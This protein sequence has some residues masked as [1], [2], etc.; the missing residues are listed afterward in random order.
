[1]KR[2]KTW[3]EKLADSKDLPR[4]E[5][6]PPG[7]SKMWGTGTIVI[8]A[9]KE[10]EEM[11][12]KVPKGKLATINSIREA[13]ALKHKATIGCPI[14]I[15]IFARI[16]AEVAKEDENE[17]KMRIIPYW[18][19]LRSGGEI[20]VKYPDGAAG[21]KKRLESEG[22]KVIAKGRKWIVQDFE[23]FLVKLE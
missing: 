10:V 4:V 9:P 11:M 18:R 7:M 5:R 3:R 23:R 19:I 17:G 12:R 15:G 8:P 20:N 1:M 14:T 2:R 13:L 6:I 16:A 21:Q 22:H